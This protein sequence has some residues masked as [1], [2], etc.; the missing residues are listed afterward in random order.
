MTQRGR[1]S[2]DAV[3]S[4]ITP[5]FTERR[6]PAPAGL[7]QPE[8][9]IW[10]DVV[11][12]SPASAFTKTHAPLLELYCKHIIRGRILDAEI[13][14]FPAEALSHPEGI[15]HYNK[16]SLMAERESRAAASLAT[17]LRI[18]RQSVDSKIVA[19]ALVNQPKSKKPWE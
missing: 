19:N 17:R 7:S 16:L 8:K 9:D 6:L 5:I 18:T 12:D 10:L 11:N 13:N 14:K 4:T 2:L 1:K 3:I 15:K